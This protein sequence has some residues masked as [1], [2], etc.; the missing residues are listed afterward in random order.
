MVERPGA[1]R[2]PAVRAETCMPM[3]DY[4][5]SLRERIGHELL[6][7]PTVSVAVFDDAGRI[8]MVRAIEDGLWSTPGGMM[9]PLETPADAAVRETW[10]ET[11]LHV[12]PTRVLGV[13]GGPD[14]AVE[15][16]NGDRIAW[17]A[18]LFAARVIGGAARPDG[19]E[20][21]LVR[22]VA[23][24]QWPTLPC[25]AHVVA[26]LSAAFEAGDGAWFAPP[27]WQP[28]DA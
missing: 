15:Y 12:T 24:D 8:L 20:T 26:F 28:P 9:E 17:V 21:D 23:R 16:G 18:T 25:R 1:P 3:S 5:R 11:G 13:F 6:E 14:C 4:V 22:Y 10:E 7:V 2:I 27:T 19:I